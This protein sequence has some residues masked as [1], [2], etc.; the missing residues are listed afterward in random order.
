MSGISSQGFG[1]VFKLEN[2][3]E[4]SQPKTTTKQT[5]ENYDINSKITEEIKKKIQDILLASV[6]Q[7]SKP[8][9]PPNL[10]GPSLNTNTYD[11]LQINDATQRFENLGYI[12]NPSLQ[13]LNNFVSP[14]V[15]VNDLISEVSSSSTVSLDSN[16]SF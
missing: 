7:S 8:Q 14:T 2:L 15:A 6:N 12:P 3:Q 10:P 11:N 4:K 13:N 1:G 5:P 16:S 9:N